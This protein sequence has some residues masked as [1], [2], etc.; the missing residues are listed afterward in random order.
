MTG[1]VGRNGAGKSTLLRLIGGVSRPDE[2]S[3][4]VNGRVGGLLNL[5]AGFHPELT[6]R[7]NLYLGAV[8]GGLTRKEVSA[9]FDSIV[10]FA[11]LEQYIDS[12]FRTYS[13]GMQMR[14]AFSI[15]VH[16]RP[17]IL[18]IDEVLAVGD[19]AFQKKCLRR[20]D[21][22]R[23][24]GC[25][26]LVVSH[27]VNII[28]ELCTSALFLREGR[29]AAH[30]DPHVVVGEYLTESGVTLENADSPPPVGGPPEPKFA[31]PRIEIQDVQLLDSFGRV[32][33]EIESDGAVSIE[34]PYVARGPVH[35]LRFRVHLCRD[36]GVSCC[37]ISSGPAETLQG[38]RHAVL[39]IEQLQLNRGLYYVDVA[40]FEGGRTYEYRD[41]LKSLT[42]R[43][44]DSGA[45]VL[46]PP[47]RWEFRP[48][49]AQEPPCLP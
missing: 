2:G 20:I 23:E 33:A 9:Q 18:L 15:A 37:E 1:V 47:H 49:R 3:V 35:D 4:E 41:K 46:R 25:A 19:C 5:G 40:A 10:S 17:G 11:E 29:L 36:D 34:I 16:T 24:D 21:R 42:I 45:G 44:A 31:L 13:S 28:D 22:L 27:D 6:G 32:T 48:A 12:P 43:A 26:I 14:L 7:E 30:G 38:R 39:H 8:I